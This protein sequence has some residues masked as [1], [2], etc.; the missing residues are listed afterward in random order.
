MFRNS[1]VFLEVAKKLGGKYVLVYAAHSLEDTNDTIY[2]PD[3]ASYYL[4]LND[5]FNHW[6][7]YEIHQFTCANDNYIAQVFDAMIFDSR[8][9]VIKYLKN[10]RDRLSI[11]TYQF[12]NSFHAIQIPT[13]EQFTSAISKDINKG[14]SVSNIMHNLLLPADKEFDE[15]IG[16]DQIW[17]KSKN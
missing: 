13:V 8:E 5:K 11:P 16:I 2:E 1:E 12:G 9:D 10:N 3:D 17:F 7:P 4:H 15:R 6:I 14:Y